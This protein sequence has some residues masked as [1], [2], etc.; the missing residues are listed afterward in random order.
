MFMKFKCNIISSAMLFTVVLEYKC[1]ENIYVV[2]TNVRK[3]IYSLNNFSL[4]IKYFD[5]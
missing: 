5:S 2:F 1:Y 4:D 3:A